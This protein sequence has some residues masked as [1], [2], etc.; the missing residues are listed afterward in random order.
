MSDTVTV[1]VERT[2]KGF[3]TY[4]RRSA[5]EMPGTPL[6][7]ILKWILEQL[8]FGHFEKQRDSRGDIVSITVGRA[9]A[10]GPASGDEALEETKGRLFAVNVN[11][12]MAKSRES[13]IRPEYSELSKTLTQ[14]STDWGHRNTEFH[15]AFELIKVLAR[16]N[17]KTFNLEAP[18]VTGL[19][20]AS[21]VSYLS[22]STRCWLYG[23]HG[24]SVA[25]SRA[26]LEEALKAWLPASDKA[27]Y[28]FTLESL[29]A[30]AK[31]RRLLDDCMADVADAVRKTANK[32]LHGES[33]TEKESR[34]T[35][36]ATR[37]LVE[38]IFS[39]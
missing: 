36:D 35:L 15:Y 10:L 20:P 5:G 25:L 34:E 22:E 7:S 27:K 13:G 18:P 9:A 8:N 29:I 28:S 2:D 4:L 31:Q 21:V 17:K 11:G 26:C 39:P 37:S 16:L 1:R 30:A 14:Q 12:M 23:F 38:Q 3:W 6:H 19:A 24:A 32:F 33:I